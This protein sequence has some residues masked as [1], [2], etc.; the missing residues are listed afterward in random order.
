MESQYFL[1][2]GPKVNRVKEELEV[3]YLIILY[4]YSIGFGI[5]SSFFYSDSMPLP[6]LKIPFAAL[7]K[8]AQV[9]R[10]LQTN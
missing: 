5:L 3:T 8:L 6:N 1:Y 7:L 9:K 10:I 4:P 2:C